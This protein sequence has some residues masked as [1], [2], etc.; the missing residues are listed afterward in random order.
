MSMKKIDEKKSPPLPV[1]RTIVKV[2]ARVPFSDALTGR[3]Y[4][5]GDIIEGWDDERCARYPQL[6]IVHSEVGPAEVK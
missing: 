4:R 6:V 1:A 3:D 5:P 2:R